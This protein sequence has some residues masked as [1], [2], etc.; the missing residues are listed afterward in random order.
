[1]DESLDCPSPKWLRLE[2]EADFFARCL[3][4]PEPHVKKVFKRV[5]EVEGTSEIVGTMAALFAVEKKVMAERL[6]E[7]DLI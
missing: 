4:M 1:M 3:L 2:A 5:K 7:L 6:V